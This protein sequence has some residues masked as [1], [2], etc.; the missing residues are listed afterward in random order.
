LIVEKVGGQTFANFLTRRIFEPLEMS[1]SGMIDLRK[2]LKGRAACYTMRDGQILNAMRVW[3]WELAP[4][5]GMYSTIE[6]LAKWEAALVSGNLIEES[7]LH[8]MWTQARL[9]DGQPVK[10]WGLGYGLGWLLADLDGKPTAEH[11]GFTGTHMMRCL[12]DSLTIIVLTNL[13]AASGNKP[14]QIARDLAHA[15]AREPGLQTKTSPAPK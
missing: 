5:F 12:D 1:D 3:Q 6:D 8:R 10:I 9:T 13:D 11:G 15:V 14:R 2:I 7:A 4:S